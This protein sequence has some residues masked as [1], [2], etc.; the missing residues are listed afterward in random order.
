MPR[1]PKAELAGAP[2]WASFGA[3]FC[4]MPYSFFMGVAVYRL[5]RLQ[6]LNFKVP[7]WV[8]ATVALAVFAMPA[9]ALLQLCIILFLL[10]MLVLAGANAKVPNPLVA[11]CTMLGK[12]SYATY[13]LHVPIIGVTIA[14]ASHA[15]EI[16]GLNNTI[17][18]HHPSLL[19]TPLAFIL[20]ISLGYLLDK[21]YDT[22]VRSWL[23]LNS[24][25]IA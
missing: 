25:K 13:A 2:A 4:R 22:P 11:G 21:Y 9:I 10:P 6:A 5:Y 15:R 24:K 7:W 12:L 19:T 8:V 14:F 3:G 16:S 1:L 18:A 20:Y 17:F 23:M